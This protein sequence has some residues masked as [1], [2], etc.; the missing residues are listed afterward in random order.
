MK[1]AWQARSEGLVLL[2][3]RREVKILSNFDPAQLETLVI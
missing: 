3:I 1:T 2:A